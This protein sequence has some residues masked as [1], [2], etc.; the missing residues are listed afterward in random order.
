MRWVVKDKTGTKLDRDL[1]LDKLPAKKP[2]RNQSH[3]GETT[4]KDRPR[5]N[6]KSPGPGPEERKHEP[7]VEQTTVADPAPPPEP[8]A[9]VEPTHPEG[10]P[11]KGAP[12]DAPPSEAQREPEQTPA[13]G[14]EDGEEAMAITRPDPNSSPSQ[15]K[16]KKKG[17]HPKEKV[18]SCWNEEEE[19][20]E[21]WKQMKSQRLLDKC[22]KEK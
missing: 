21:A 9:S 19:I 7:T 16:R 14:T 15:S 13:T 20:E 18:D 17:K 3:P 2:S 6:R 12:T 1:F 4:Q 22:R 5:K 11:E 8:A 10:T